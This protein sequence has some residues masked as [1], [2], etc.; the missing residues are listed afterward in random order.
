M[1]RKCKNIL[2]RKERIKRRNRKKSA[3]T[4]WIPKRR[5]EK[6]LIVNP[7]FV[8]KKSFLML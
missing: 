1:K 5:S 8:V 3:R 4:L 7:F 2:K 6:R